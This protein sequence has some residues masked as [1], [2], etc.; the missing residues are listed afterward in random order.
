MAATA[1]N[2]LVVSAWTCCVWRPAIGPGPGP[3]PW[4]VPPVTLS[5]SIAAKPCP[6]M[7]G[8]VI[9]TATAVGAPRAPA[10]RQA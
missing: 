5:A 2:M 8:A 9:A 3:C 7:A 6:T 10:R 4:G 1:I